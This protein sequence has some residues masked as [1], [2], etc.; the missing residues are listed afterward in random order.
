MVRKFTS[1]AAILLFSASATLLTAAVP[2]PAANL[3]YS[4]VFY[5]DASYTAVVGY[6][7]QRCVGYYI[8]TPLV[9]GETSSYVV[10][11]PIGTC[12]GL[13]W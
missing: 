6:Y 11:E 1:V 9:T 8:E 7:T 12:P 13:P 2:A 10:R 3:Y 4:Y 5:S